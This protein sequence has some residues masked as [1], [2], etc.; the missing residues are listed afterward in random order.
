MP[1]HTEGSNGHDHSSSADTECSGPSKTY[2]ESVAGDVL[3][4]SGRTRLGVYREGRATVAALIQR[5]RIGRAGSDDPAKHIDE[6]HSH[7]DI[8]A[9]IVNPSLR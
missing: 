4:T 3:A 2:L 5:G 1:I 6:S 8:L 9:P 7:D